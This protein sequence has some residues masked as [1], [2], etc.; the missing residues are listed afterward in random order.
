[1]S[2]KQK[3]IKG[4]I[5]DILGSFSIQIL[6]L[7]L[8]PLYLDL[9]SEELYGLWLTLGSVIAWISMGD[10]GI[11]ISLT[12]KL[13]KNNENNDYIGINKLIYSAFV[14]FL[15]VGI[16]FVSIFYIFFDS[17]I[18]FFKIKDSMLLDF[19]NTYLVI[20]IFTIIKMP[21]NVFKSF[22][23]SKQEISYLKIVRA[24]FEFITAFITLVF[25]YNDFGIISFAYGLI[26]T[27]IFEPIIDVLYLKRI[28]K[29][30]NI[31]PIIIS[32]K[33]IKSLFKLG[34]KIQ[35][36]KISNI[37]ATNTDNFIILGYMGAS[38][39]SIYVFSTKIAVIVA[40]VFASKLPTILFPAISQLFEQKKFKKLR[41]VYSLLF[42]NSLRFTIIFGTIFYFINENFINLWVGNK[43][44]GGNDLN[45][46]FVFYII[47][48]SILRSISVFLYASEDLTKLSILSI[49]EALLNIS[50]SLF[51]VND[52]GLIGL[53]L[54][55]IISKL[56]T[57]FFYVPYAIN[58][59]LNINFSYFFKNN[60]LNVV[61]LSL[62]TIIVPLFFYNIFAFINS[63][64]FFIIMIPS[65]TL[66][67]NFMFF[68]GYHIKKSNIKNFKQLLNSISQYH[69]V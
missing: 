1:M 18:L 9:T 37:V 43:Y 27:A 66:I 25:L 30:F 47:V 23:E 16:V 48:E 58:K 61:Y 45:L 5:S 39:V 4:F 52:Y 60:V 38:F 34:Y 40:L 46:V 57:T 68:E 8:V 14:T 41:S 19:K 28:D 24:I 22:I 33:D 65:I 21:L 11:G 31:F 50:I 59:I 12:R 3:S 49:I 35:L 67:S 36:L 51:L 56:L 29:N 2:R 6:G 69:S 32:I 20:L 64:L 17:F 63:D 54:G 62:P 7:I 26:I 44:Y 55:T 10:M 53:A 13:V 15:L 42:R